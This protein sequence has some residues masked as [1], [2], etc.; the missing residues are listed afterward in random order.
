MNHSETLGPGRPILIS[1]ESVDARIWMSE[2]LD[3]AEAKSQLTTGQTEFDFGQAVSCRENDLCSLG[4]SGR[5]DLLT[6]HMIARAV[7][8]T[9][10]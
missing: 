8:P 5:G 6:N 10:V 9:I 7:K 4:I 3:D 1:S 2:E